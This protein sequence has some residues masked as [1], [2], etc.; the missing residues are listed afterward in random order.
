MANYVPD[1]SAWIPTGQWTERKR[2]GRAA[3]QRTVDHARRTLAGERRALT[4]RRPWANL[5]FAGKAV[6][7]RSWV[8]DHRGELVV[9]GGQAWAPDGA[10]LAAELGIAGFDTPRTCP[11]GYLGTVRLVDVHT[12]AGCCAP[13][14]QQEPGIYHWVL[15]DPVLFE[16]PI[17]GRGRLGLH[18]LPADVVPVRPPTR[19]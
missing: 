1:G 2:A 9:H 13:W 19:P 11:G 15:A 14:G 16:R 3:E 5:I 12:A 18:W 7:N 6:E 8:T 4:V 10:A 17:S